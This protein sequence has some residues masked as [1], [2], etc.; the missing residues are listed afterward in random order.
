MSGVHY[1]AVDPGKTGAVAVESNDGRRHVLRD[2]TNEDD[3]V[4]AIT[5]ARN[6][7]T[8]PRTVA[9]VIEHVHAVRGQGVTST[10]NFGYYYGIARGALQHAGGRVVTVEPITWQTWVRKQANARNVVVDALSGAGF[11]SRLAAVMFWPDHQ[12]FFKRVKDHNSGDAV[13]ILEWLK[14]KTL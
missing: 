2:F 1:I 8:V 12:H 4:D 3:L 10:F 13:C 9:T 6:W 14:A 11:D 5:W 7:G